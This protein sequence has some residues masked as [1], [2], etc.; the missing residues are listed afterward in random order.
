MADDVVELDKATQM[1]MAFDPEGYPNF[2]PTIY[3]GTIEPNNKCRQWNSKREKY[4]GQSAGHNTDHKGE[5][6]CRWHS[7]GGG[8]TLKHG[9]Y[10]KVTRKSVRE[11]LKKIKEQSIEERMS[12]VEEIDM[13]RALAKD[14]VET[15]DERVEKLMAWNHLEAVDAAMEER[16]S[17]PQPIP[18][19]KDVSGLLM[20]VVSAADRMHSQQYRDAIPK[21]D[22][23]R[24]QEAMGDAVAKYIMEGLKHKVSEQVLLDVIEK[25]QQH[26]DGIRL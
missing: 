23:F 17:R 26:W 21:K 7:H 22:F 25:I 19:L 18:E 1:D 2:V 24:V 10:S 6:R 9:M 13:L 16:K 4:C 12:L 14:F 15:Y 3:L 11:H 5:G 20:K 8:K